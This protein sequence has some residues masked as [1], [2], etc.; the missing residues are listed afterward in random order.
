MGVFTLLFVPETKHVPIEAIEDQ[1]FKKHWFW[2]KVRLAW[3]VWAGFV[4]L[5]LDSAAETCTKQQL[6]TPIQRPNNI[7][8]QIMAKTYASEAEAEAK[9]AA[10]TDDDV[11]A[12][13]ATGVHVTLAGAEKHKKVQSP[14][15][16]RD[17]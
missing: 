6:P 5:G 8:M 3:G 13:D 16:N 2:G 11:A 7:H 14:F 15:F 1:L 17:A 4:W 12:R 9:A 10:I